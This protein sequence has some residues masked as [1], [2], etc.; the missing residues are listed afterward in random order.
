MPQHFQV[1]AL[2]LEIIVKWQAGNSGGILQTFVVQ[3][4]NRFESE[5]RVILAEGKTSEVIDGLQMSTVYFVRMFSRNILGKSN[6][7]EEIIIKTG[8]Y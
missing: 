8:K 2:K 7:T 3:Y 6:T 1:V 4:R 5:W